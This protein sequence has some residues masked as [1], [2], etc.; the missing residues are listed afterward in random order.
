MQNLTAESDLFYQ[1]LREDSPEK[2][3]FKEDRPK[4]ILHRSLWPSTRERVRNNH[5]FAARTRFRS[6]Y[7]ARDTPYAE[8]K[9]SA[10]S[11]DFNYTAENR[12]KQRHEKSC[13][14][15]G[16]YTK[17]ERPVKQELTSVVSFHLP[18]HRHKSVLERF[19]LQEKQRFLQKHQT[20]LKLAIRIK[21]RPGRTVLAELPSIS[22]GQTLTK[23]PSPGAQPK[24]KHLKTLG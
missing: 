6:P 7:Y 9:A 12:V 16:E 23:V 1:V 13:S 24:I 5:N 21:K 19:V 17:T 18:S 15:L 4:P 11:G 20:S 10:P 22:R 8:C 2:H 14:P 3:L